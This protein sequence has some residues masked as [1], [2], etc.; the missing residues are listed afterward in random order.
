MFQKLQNVTQVPAQSSSNGSTLSVPSVSFGDVKTKPSVNRS[1]TPSPSV[2]RQ[3][4]DSESKSNKD[5][6]SEVVKRKRKPAAT[7]GKSQVPLSINE[8]VYAPYDVYIANT[9]PNCTDDLIKEVLTEIADNMPD[10]MKLNEKFRILE[11]ECQTKPREGVKIYSKSWRVRVE[12]KFKEHICRPEAIPPGWTSRK[13][14]YRREPR[15]PHKRPMLA[16]GGQQPP[17]L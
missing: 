12:N 16:S 4:E 8:N 13:F 10:E 7:R 17:G 3:H 9:H 14:Y 5:D 1:R 2:K 11:V 15:N 6:W